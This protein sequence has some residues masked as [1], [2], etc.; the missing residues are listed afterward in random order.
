[1]NTS[2][3]TQILVNTLGHAGG[4]VIFGIFLFLLVRYRARTRLRGSRLSL[5]AAALAFL[6]NL[7]S[8]FVLSGF[9]LGRLG[10]TIFAAIA[11][12]VLSFMP[13]LLLDLCLLDRLRPLVWSG[14]LIS[15]AAVILH[16]V[17][18][19][20]SD[21]DYHRVAL[22]IITVGFGALTTV[23]AALVIQSKQRGRGTLTSR[24]LA[25]M[26]LFIFAV[27]FVHFGEGHAN[28]AWSTELA[29]HHAGIPLALLVLLQD[30]RFVLL[31][32]FIRFLANVLLAAVFTYGIV[33]GASVILARPSDAFRTGLLLAAGC[34]LLIL[35][36]VARTALQRLLTRLMFRRPPL[37][38]ALRELQALAAVAADESDFLSAVARLAGDFIGAE[39]IELTDRNAFPDSTL[40]RPVLAASLSEENVEAGFEMVVPIRLAQGDVR[41]LLLGARRGGKRYLSEDIDALSILAAHISEQV[42]RYRES[43]MRRLVSQAE[44][45]ALQA[46]INPHF[47]FNALNTLYGIIP[48]DASGARRTVLNLADIF[49]YFLS[50]EKTF[51]PLEDELRI[52][53]AYL[54]IEQLRLGEKLHA[55]IVT[56]EADRSRLIPVL[57]IQPLVENAVKHGV[58]KRRDGGRVRV[59]IRRNDG[60]LVISVEDDGPGFAR[61]G[62]TDKDAHAGIGLDNVA[63]R[64]KLCF[65]P[66]ADLRVEE[67]SS[68]TSVGFL[69][70]LGRDA[71]VSQRA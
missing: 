70:P 18:T 21:T 12:S 48:R 51:I 4:V 52:V 30:Y 68:G 64:L 3:D 24:L 15:G 55:E 67:S 66:D 6:W 62:D 71:G 9:S 46:Q 63:R 60:N 8:I 38:Q 23:T 59:V 11:F 44:L 1:M 35:Y 20:A 26:S 5:A 7:A 69:V 58:A 29:I 2:F 10:T 54:E 17:E 25:T 43:E 27:S 13:A 50:S 28:Q 57:S 40:V 34:L 65:G 16:I 45:R 31:D 36:A 39:S 37:E 41:H 49:R 42:D 32:A 53:R 56:D 22:T 61:S 47:L 19:F 14:Y 33:F